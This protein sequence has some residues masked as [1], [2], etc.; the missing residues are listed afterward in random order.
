MPKSFIGLAEIATEHLGQQLVKKAIFAFVN[1]RRNRIN[2]LSFD[3]T[4]LRVASSD[5]KKEPLAGPPVTTGRRQKTVSLHKP[6]NSS[7]TALISKEPP[8]APGIKSHN[9]RTTQQKNIFLL[10]DAPVLGPI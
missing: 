4:G 7:S 5:L 1:K 10:I 6:S 2:L 8:C 9:S 3:G